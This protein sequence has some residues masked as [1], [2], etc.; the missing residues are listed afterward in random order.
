MEIAL[1]PR[2][3][4]VAVAHFSGR[5]DFSSA[6]AARGCFA[7]A[8]AGGHTK[9]VA[10]FGQ[11]EFLDSA[12]L[13]AL[14]S[15]MRTSHQAGGDLHI[16]RPNEQVRTL[17]ELTSLDQVLRTHASIEEAIDGFSR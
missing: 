10:D 3:D 1:E 12:G 5:L 16:A 13:G 11:V 2:E 14:I 7:D 9:L 15:G 4:H 6:A 8:V 17:L